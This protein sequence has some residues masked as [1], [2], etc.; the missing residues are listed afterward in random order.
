[1]FDIPQSDLYR[2]LSEARA[3]GKRMEF[4]DQGRLV[5]CN[6]MRMGGV[7]SATIHEHELM[8]RAKESDD[9]GEVAWA[10]AMIRSNG[11]LEAGRGYFVA[12]RV[13]NHNLLPVAGINDCWNTWLG[14]TS[15]SATWYIA[16]FTSNS[17]PASDWLSNWAGASSGPKATELAAVQYNESGRQVSAFGAASGGVIASSSSTRYTLATG[18]SGV[19]IYGAVL[20]NV[21]TVAYN[22]TDKVLAAAT[23]F[24]SPITGLAATHKIDFQ[25]QLTGTSS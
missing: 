1:M 4:D 7:F 25:Y 16:A 22:V 11:D 24:A 23:R 3:N 10:E 15:K 19:S 18:Q 2:V 12:D 21:A 5:V 6:D 17:T 20:T 8:A 14:A 13:S 9:P